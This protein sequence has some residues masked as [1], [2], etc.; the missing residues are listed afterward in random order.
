MGEVP[1]CA[2]VQGTGTE[3]EDPIPANLQE[4]AEK[5]LAE[6]DGPLKLA[7]FARTLYDRAFAQGEPLVALAVEAWRRSPDDPRVRHAAEWAMEQRIPR[8]HYGILRDDVRNYAY[9]QALRAHVK[10]GMIVLEIGAGSGLLAM[11]AARAGAKHVYACEMEPLLA[12]VA[13]ENVQRNGLG[14]RVTILAKHS[15]DIVMGEDM[16]QRADLLVSEIVDNALLG[17]DLLASVEDARTRLL[18]EGGTMLPDA[19]SLRGL[20]IEMPDVAPFPVKEAMDLDVS[21]IDRYTP[22]KVGYTGTPETEDEGL[23][24]TEDLLRFDLARGIVP[25]PTVE[26]TLRGQRDGM[27][28]GCLTWI[29]LDFAGAGTLEV[30]PGEP[31]S[32]APVLHAFA[33]PVRVRKGMPVRIVVEHDRAGLDVRPA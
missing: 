7:R 12:H 11:L 13:W 23:T 4:V 22:V 9:A 28:Y 14:G 21:A 29:R 26:V 33:K 15:G 6:P 30:K 2:R 18:A 1:G 5:L 31:S 27:A 32:W 10:P 8:W 20:L 25:P 16:P 17:E 24:R 3:H 19:G